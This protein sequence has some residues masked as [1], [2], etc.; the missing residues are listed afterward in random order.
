MKRTALREAAPSAH[1]P[2][3]TSHRWRLADGGLAVVDV[4]IGDRSDLSGEGWQV[5]SC[6][7]VSVAVRLAL[8]A[9]AAPDNGCCRPGEAGRC[10]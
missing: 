4:Q 9:G 3:R 10:R 8:S 2:I 5:I 7:P 6:G 1:W